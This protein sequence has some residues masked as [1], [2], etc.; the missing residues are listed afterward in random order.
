MS[1]PEPLSGEKL[2]NVRK[3]FK[4]NPNAEYYD[5]VVMVRF[6]DHHLLL[7]RSDGPALLFELFGS[8]AVG[9]NLP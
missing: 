6:T 5:N 8:Q 9:T 2:D 3:Q 7:E 4:R 1:K